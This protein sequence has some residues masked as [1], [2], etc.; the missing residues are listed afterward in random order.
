MARDYAKIPLKTRKSPKK[1]ASWLVLGMISFLILSGF[2]GVYWVYTHPVTLTHFKALFTHSSSSHPATQDV[3]AT[4]DESNVHF[5]FY[6]V[7]PQT[8]PLVTEHDNVVPPPPNKQQ[9][10]NQVPQYVLLLG[11]YKSEVEAGELRVSLLLSGADATMV[12]IGSG[13]NILYRIQQ[14]P[15]TTLAAA[16]TA[17]QKLQRKGIL[18]EIIKT[19]VVN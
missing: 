11:T 5:D 6:T 17:R 14:G 4:E 16:K 2:Y 1:Q 18:G 10:A 9:A 19:I 7:L 3:A 13:K 12:K 8:K 15:F